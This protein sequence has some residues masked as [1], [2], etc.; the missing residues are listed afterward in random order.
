MTLIHRSL[1]LRAPAFPGPG[2]NLTQAAVLALGL[3]LGCCPVAAWGQTA[4]ALAP[5]LVAETGNWSDDQTQQVTGYLR[6][7]VQALLSAEEAAIERS[8]EAILAPFGTAG[9][10]EP[11]KPA[12]RPRR[13]PRDRARDLASGFV[14]VR[15]NA[16][17]LAG[18]LPDPSA[19]DPVAAG[20]Q[21]EDA[22]VRYLAAVA[23]NGLIVRD[24]LD[25][26]QRGR[27]LQLVDR[28]LADEGQ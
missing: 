3:G 5:G 7:H 14:Q 27:I 28:Q 19:L 13:L 12:V 21:D 26:D 10:S 23:L 25:P 6:G 4:G 9:V 22:G 18:R 17:I 24:Q 1:P 15:V 11:F 16:M 20:L 8:R 2:R